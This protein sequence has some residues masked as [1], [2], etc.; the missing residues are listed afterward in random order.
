MGLGVSAQQIFQPATAQSLTGAATYCTTAS[1]A[2]PLVFTYN[3]CNSGTGVVTP[4][5]CTITWYYNTTNSTVVAGATVAASA[6]VF[7]SATTPLGSRSFTP[8][9][10]I[11]G[12]FYY[13]CVISWTGGT[14]SCPGGASNFITSGTQL[15]T[16]NTLPIAGPSSVCVG[17]TATLTDAGTGGVW[18][19]QNSTVASVNASGVIT[20][21]S[22]GNVNIYYT[23]AGCQ[24]AKFISV[25]DT[26]FAIVPASPSVCVGATTTLSDP[27]AGGIWT[28]ATSFATVN[29]G[30]GVVTGVAAG[31]TRITYQF[32]STGCFTTRIVTVNANPQPITGSLVVCNGNNTTLSDITPGGNWSSSNTTIATVG[33]ATGIVHGNAQGTATISYIVSGCYAT[34]VVS[35]G[36]PA[37]P[38]TGPVYTV[39]SGGSTITL[40]DPTSGGTWS[41]GST[42]AS[43]N[44]TGVVTGVN[45]GNA[46]IS[47]TT[48]GCNA[49]TRT[50]T[51]NPL[52]APITGILNACTGLTTSLAS[53]TTG[54][55]FSS[56]NTSVVTIDSAN[57]IASGISL[58]TSV[59]T[60]KVGNSGC[61]ATAVVTVHPF[62]PIVGSDTICVG[63]G[64]LLTDIVGG[65]TWA[66]S[67]PANATIGASSGIVT[68]VV[69]GITF[70]VYTIGA[71]S[72]SHFLRILPPLPAIAGVKEICS[73]SVSA[74]SDIAGGGRWST[75]NAFIVDVDAV[76][77]MASASFPGNAVVTYTNYGCVTTAVITVNPLPAAVVS[78]NWGTHT[79]STYNY[80]THY[81]W[82]DSSI[83]GATSNPIPGA[84]NSTLVIPVMN[85]IYRVAVTDTKGCT[86][87]T[88]W[89][90]FT[91]VSNIDPLSVNVYPNPAVNTVFIE[92]PVKLKAVISSMAGQVLISLDE[93]REINIADLAKGIYILSLS[94]DTGQM[95]TVRKLLKE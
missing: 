32:P 86:K 47:Y 4:A 11:A 87:S 62:A 69:D 35:V 64:T 43:V 46:D 90:D 56:S 57:G 60:Y 68:G 30:T 3:T 92:S 70:I 22:T 63:S 59:I 61:V 71:C 14:A 81:Q 10:S 78:Y 74:L 82:Y 95:V 65:G 36:I 1:A 12:T 91:S 41:S 40:S 66:S 54:G 94:D 48:P 29:A 31:N 5:S 85:K 93:A 39:C 72:T 16:V 20:G 18:S 77:G 73:G 50:I 53:S 15:V 89:R 21:V 9:T 79:L 55:T 45:A 27:S 7:P 84:T 76:T 49:V 37:A 52:P 8:P 19:S 33:G 2:A 24:A 34:A 67:N 13:F 28:A 23:I 44:S 25:N 26:P 38:I 83:G 58:G 17:S 51:I 80:F 42:N 6:T 88:V 75:D